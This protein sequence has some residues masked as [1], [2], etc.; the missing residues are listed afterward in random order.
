MNTIPSTAPSV[1]IGIDIAKASLQV[2]LPSG[3]ASFPNTPKGHLLLA[4][5]LPDRAFVVMEATGSYYLSLFAFLHAR[6]I[7]ASVLNPAWIKAFARC[8]GLIAKTDPIDA[9]TLSAYGRAFHPKAS[10]PREPD[11]VK[12]KEL[13]ALRDHLLGE[14]TALG[15]R[16][17]HG[18]CADV[19]RITSRLIKQAKTSLA[20]IDKTI[21]ALLS[22]SPALSGHSRVIQSSKGVGPVTAAVLLSEMPELGR[23]T[24]KEAAALAGL[25]PF[26]NDSG[27]ASG[28]RHVRA[29]RPRVKRALYLASLSAVRF[30]PQLK[31][32]YRDLR[33]KGKPAKVALVAVARRLLSIINAKLKEHIDSSQTA[34]P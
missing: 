2:D 30:H 24:R 22:D 27:T 18:Q 7:P 28:K 31:E 9:T 8:T 1:H 20:S 4:S 14:I 11:R 5:S 26:A 32:T 15:N 10:T 29:G 12:L 25:A 13:L 21:A 17:E 23:M 19:S 16:L 33:A 34:N 3:S 6:G